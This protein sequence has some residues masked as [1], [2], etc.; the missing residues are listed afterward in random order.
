MVSYVFRQFPEQLWEQA[1]A[2]A[3]GKDDESSDREDCGPADDAE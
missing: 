2:V 1:T 3:A